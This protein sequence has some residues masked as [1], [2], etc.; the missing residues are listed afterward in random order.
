MKNCRY[1]KDDLED[2]KFYIRKHSVDGLSIYC[3]KCS[4]KKTMESRKR[5]KIKDPLTNK[6]KY[7]RKFI[8]YEVGS[9]DYVRDHILRSKYNISLEDYKIL[10]VNQN[11]KC[12][13]CDRHINELPKNLDVDHCHTTGKVRGLLC[14]KCNMGLGYFQ[15]DF[16]LLQKAIKYLNFSKV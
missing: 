14:G 3:K 16:Q 2:E 8:M 11:N 4:S 9:R 1:C 12:A 7:K 5:E 6:V 10:Q 13:I 15:D